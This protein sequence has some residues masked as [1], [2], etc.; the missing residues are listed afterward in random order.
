MR[1]TR[2]TFGED[3][4]SSKPLLSVLS[5]GA[6]ENDR[7]HDDLAMGS[8]GIRHHGQQRM[9]SCTWNMQI[10]DSRTCMEQ[11][12]EDW[13]YLTIPT[14][15]LASQ[16]NAINLV[17][18]VLQGLSSRLIRCVVL[19]VDSLNVMKKT[20]SPS[21]PTPPGS[22]LHFLDSFHIRTLVCTVAGLPM[23]VYSNQ[24]DDVDS[25]FVV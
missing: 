17:N 6:V 14:L 20:D 11:C 8:M 16:S 15:P 2:R 9:A 24:R 7:K 18:L 12:G 13:M 19:Q 22:F 3:V 4:I 21:N 1:L 23:V 10:N 25:V 5:N